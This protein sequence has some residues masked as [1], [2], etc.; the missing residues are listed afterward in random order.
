MPRL[1]IS[2]TMGLS[3]EKRKRYGRKNVQNPAA[4][5]VAPTAGGGRD[6][7]HPHPSPAALT[8]R[9]TSRSEMVPAPD[10]PESALLSLED[11]PQ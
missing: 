3:S 9:F 7:L 4:P 11:K 8:P 1:T 2:S 10:M 6:R 5:C